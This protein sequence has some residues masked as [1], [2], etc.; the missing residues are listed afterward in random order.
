MSEIQRRPQFIPYSEGQQYLHE[1]Y[2]FPQVSIRQLRTWIKAGK[3][4]E[5]IQISPGRKAFTDQQLDRHAE[6]KLALVGQLDRHT[7]A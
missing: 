4:P 6:A 3:F 1:K 2:G 5:P 7:A